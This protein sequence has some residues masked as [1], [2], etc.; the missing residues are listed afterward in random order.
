MINPAE[1]VTIAALLEQLLPAALVPLF[2]ASFIRSDILYDE[3]VYRLAVQVVRAVG[4][5]A[6]ACEPG[7]SEEIARNAGLDTERALALDSILR[8]LAARHV[9]E[10]GGT[11][12][13]NRRFCVRAPLPTLDPGPIRDEQ[14]RHDSS[15]LPSYALAETVAQDYPAFLRGEVAGERI[16]F[17]PAQFRLWFD[18]FSNDNTLYAV[19][20]RAGA[21]AVEEWMPRGV[22]SIL[23]LGG[24]LASAT[25]ALLERLEQAGRLGDIREYRFTELVPA[26]LRR[27]QHTLQTRFSAASFLMFGQLD[28]NRRFE[29][30]G[31]ARGSVSVVYAVNTL[32]VAHNLGFTL[33]EIFR[34]L[35]PGGRLITSECVRPWPGQAIYAEFVFNLMETFRSP[36]LH[37]VYRP[38]GGFLTP[39]QWTTAMQAA[40]FADVRL[41]PDIAR[42]R[43]RIPAFCVAAIGATRPFRGPQRSG[44]G[45]RHRRIAAERL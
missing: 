11:D 9:L 38:N 36:V 3:F 35:E 21:I 32:H 22:G 15:C 12:D 2:D 5:E 14:Y 34:A 1:I 13:A 39:E 7:T 18:Y 27:G 44:I 31:V 16:L 30:Q 23:E 10:E 8:R 20:N 28:M 40:G 25:T 37:P 43:D 19:N 6:A 24:G 29:E 42:L 4:L 17:S 26:F 33:G 45:V 41:L